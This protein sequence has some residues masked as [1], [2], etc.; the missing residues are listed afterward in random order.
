M[1]LADPR[2][3]GV[4]HFHRDVVAWCVGGGLVCALVRWASYRIGCQPPISLWGRIVNRRLFIPRF[5]QVWIGPMGIAMTTAVLALTLCR[6]GWPEP[7]VGGLFA[8]VVLI[9]TFLLPPRMREWRM[10]GEYH[11]VRP[12]KQLG[13][14]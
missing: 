5:D 7:V 14:E 12:P 11:V 8:T 13:V 4:A 10:T 6:A 9:V 3:I 2:D 1:T